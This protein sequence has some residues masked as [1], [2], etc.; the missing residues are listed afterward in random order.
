MSVP[1]VFRFPASSG[2]RRL[3]LLDQ[4]L[5]GS[6]V[7]NIGWRVAVDGPLDVDRLRSALADVVDR[8]EALRTTL[9]APDGV[10][11]QVVA[12]TVP[13]ELPVVDVAATEVAARVRDQV[14]VAFDLETGPLFRAVL[15]RLTA[16]RHV[17]VLVLHHAI[18]DGW[19]CAVLFDELARRYAGEDLPEP[20]IGYPD[21][22]LWQQEQSFDDG[23]WRERLRDVP[24]VLALPTDRPRPERPTGRGAEL[25][26]RIRVGDGSFARLLA[27]FGCVLHRVTGQADLLVATPVAARTRPE[28]EGLVG[29]VANTVPLR[30]TFDEDTTVRDAVTAA[31][32]ETVAA[33]AHQ[34]LPFER[35]VELADVPR[36]LAHSP[37]VQ[38]LFAVEPVPGVRT[39][40]DV[41]FGPEPVHNGG[42]KFDLSL[43]VERAGEDWF[44][45][46]QYD[47]ELFDRASVVAL[48]DAFTAV[49]DAD[50]DT[51]VAELPLVRSTSDTAAG[52]VLDAVAAH[53]DAVAL[54]GEL[55]CGELDRAANRLAHA[56]LAAGAR[57]DEPVA[58]CL[59]RGAAT[60][61]GVLAA[62]KAGAGYLPLDP[63]WPVHRLTSMATDAGTPVLVTDGS[64]AVGGPWTT[65]DS[66][67][68]HEFPDTPPQ[69]VP[70]HPGMLAYVLYTSGSTGTPKGVRVTQGGLGALLSAMDD[71]LDL[72][73]DDLLASI[74]TPAFDVSTVEMFV[75]LLRGVPLTVLDADEVADGALLRA[76]IDESGAT[77]VQ[78]GPASWRMVV[79]AGGVPDRVR[80]RISG[81]EAMTRDLADELQS[82]GATVIDGYG[83]TE[84]TVYSAVG[85]VARAPHP[86]RLG[87]AIAGT[88][89]HVLD[90]ALRPVPPGV[91]GELHIGGAG[92]ARG[93]HGRPDLTAAKFVP[94][95][96]GTG[97][98]LYATGDLVRRRVDGGLE[99]LGR[100]DRQL[101]IRGYRIEP[102][103]VE[104]VLRAHPDVADAVVVAWS[105]NASD[106]RLVAYVVPAAPA[107]VRE[108]LAAHLPEYMLPASVVDLESVPRTGTGKVDRS[109]LPEPTWH[110]ASADRVEPRDETEASMAVIW[111]AVLSIPEDVPLGVHDNFFALGGHSL[112]ATQMLARVRTTLSA[113]VPLAALFAAPTIAGLSVAVRGADDH[114]ARG[115]V[116][117]LDQLDD[118][119][120]AEIDRLLG[121]LSDGEDVL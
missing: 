71:V 33:V 103:E 82:G 97:G 94:D 59:D 79:A 64:V 22:A 70:Q 83:P 42:A 118:L 68:V 53:P 12:S 51:P 55:T 38:V 76:R 36:S 58:L 41:R 47:A 89:L 45:R 56:L 16:D 116:P 7:Y 26:A 19:S 104:A 17:L 52:L 61:V 115:P 43:T 73:S 107:D 18:A 101:K 54:A 120:D 105:A 117:L 28:T 50:A 112:T 113:Q 30:A 114:L 95:P 49:L 96:F 66:R 84:T 111:R 9:V 63:S 109:A 57:P 20:P 80:L 93:Y 92:V 81:G 24:T 77:V 29:F 106:V 102:G 72:G 15:L 13:V 46:W 48:H 11:E 1:E 2:Q 60:L 99:F 78:G 110:T 21:Y 8:H 35:I 62:W 69:A 14:R 31:E 37:L 3:W 86:V 87:P 5:P 67:A 90:R 108:H 32:R 34:D 40:G 119:S 121:T 88:T 85:V 27:L 91:I 23:Y 98:R 6:P 75:P 4:L 74:T 10:P 39:A 44:A 25:R 100:A 65:V